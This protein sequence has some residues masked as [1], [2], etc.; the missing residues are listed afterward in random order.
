MSMDSTSSHTKLRILLI[1]SN[2]SIQSQSTFA[3]YLDSKSGRTLQSWIADIDASFYFT[4][5][6][7]IKTPNNRQLT[8]KEIREALPHLMQEIRIVNPD[9]IVA[10]G[11]TAVE[12][13]TLHRSKID[14]RLEW[15]EMPHPS[16]LNRKL[17]SKEYKEQKI[18]ELAAF[19]TASS[20]ESKTN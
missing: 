17:N 4:N 19:C 12:A 3:F 20:V 8:K 1:G 14:G 10:L 7:N 6:S 5:V 2:P 9:R 15:L 11:N 18:K 13:L 16:G